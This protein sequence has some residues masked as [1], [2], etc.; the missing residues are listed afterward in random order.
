MAIF[1]PNSIWR[2]ETAE[3]S[4]RSSVATEAAA[5]AAAPL[6]M[7]MIMIMAVVVMMLLSVGKYSGER[8]VRV[9][10]GDVRC[11]GK[12]STKHTRAQMLTIVSLDRQQ[13]TLRP[14][15]TRVRRQGRR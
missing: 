10:E 11:T 13:A 7:I 2:L 9:V 4:Q 15:L 14:T 3:A 6:L 12:I 8:C 5:A 1:Y